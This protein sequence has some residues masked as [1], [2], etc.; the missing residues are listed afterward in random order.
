M[1][2]WSIPACTVIVFVFSV[3]ST[4]SVWNKPSNSSFD[5]LS[6]HDGQVMALSDSLSRYFSSDD[7]NSWVIVP[8][9][10]DLWPIMAGLVN[11]LDK[12]GWNVSVSSN[13]TFMTG[14]GTDVNDI[15]LYLVPDS[16]S[17][18]PER[19]VLFHHENILI[20]R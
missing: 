19:E 6:Y 4:A 16:C 20:C 9:E 12:Y 18:I 13:F 14:I 1:W 8:A 7:E 10:H 3:M 11:R 15:P 17:I 5:P 2:R